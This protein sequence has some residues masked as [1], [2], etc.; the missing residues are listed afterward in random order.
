[1]SFGRRRRKKAAAQGQTA[2]ITLALNH[3]AREQPESRRR[4]GGELDAALRDNTEDTAAPHK[5]QNK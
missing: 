2:E 5:K 1:M 4:A 3:A